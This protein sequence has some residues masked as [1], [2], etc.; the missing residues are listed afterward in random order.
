MIHTWKGKPIAALS[1]EELI[2]VVNWFSRELET[3]REDRNAWMKSGSAVQYMLQKDIK[4]E[5]K[6]IG[7]VTYWMPLPYTYHLGPGGW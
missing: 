4:G 7:N 5:I 6:S 2:E 1:R 3:L